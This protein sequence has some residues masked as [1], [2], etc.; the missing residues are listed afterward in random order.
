[1]KE[2]KKK[3]FPDFIKNLLGYLLEIQL[4]LKDTKL[5]IKEW[6]GMHREVLSRRMVMWPYQYQYQSRL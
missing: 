6:K 3:R 2:I 4:K 1:M 5:K